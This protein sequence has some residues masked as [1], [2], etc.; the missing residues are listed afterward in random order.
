MSSARAE[1]DALSER[2][3]PLVGSYR[4]AAE[5]H[6]TED[7]LRGYADLFGYRSDRFH[8]A[9]AAV[10]EG[11]RG[12]VAPAAFAAVYTMQAVLVALH[13]DELGVPFAW[14]LHAG[15]SL[16]IGEPV[17]AGDDITTTVTLRDVIPKPPNLFYVL[18]TRSTLADGAVC[19]T[20]SSTQVVR[21]P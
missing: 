12:L 21:F 4:R 1:L 2:W 19:A 3:R 11:F 5:Y 9:E 13:D 7:V 17:C 6:A 10:A 14:N 16:E 18:E 8:R 20:G 15:Q